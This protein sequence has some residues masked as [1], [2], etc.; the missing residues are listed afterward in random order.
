M[1]TKEDLFLTLGFNSS[2][3]GV[4]DIKA[5]MFSGSLFSAGVQEQAII[6][7]YPGIETTIC[8]YSITMDGAMIIEISSPEFITKLV[9]EAKDPE[10]KSNCK[11][12][13]FEKYRERRCCFIQR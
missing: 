11:V 7:E 3:Q 5:K 6:Q 8:R 12:F 10:V 1:T 13:D 9:N 2:S 4:A